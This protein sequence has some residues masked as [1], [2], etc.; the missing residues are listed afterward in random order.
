MRALAS[1]AGSDGDGGFNRGGRDD[2]NA[3]NLD[4]DKDLYGILGLERG[5]SPAKIKA[6]Y[7]R[8]AKEC[9]PD[10]VSPE[11]ADAAADRFRQVS[12]AHHTLLHTSLRRMYDLH[13][14]RVEGI[15]A[16]ADEEDRLA[17]RLGRAKPLVYGLGFS[18]AGIAALMVLVYCGQ[19]SFWSVFRY[20]PEWVPGKYYLPELHLQLH[21][22]V[23]EFRRPASA[24]SQS[25]T[26]V[27]KAASP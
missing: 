13:L 10:A 9:H 23:R 8:I 17:G 7:R 12:H 18:A 3:V 19:W 21:E 24:P 5:A 20:I 14:R 6:A 22:A 25:D 2:A 16:C 27:V 11:E 26:V 1:T 15:N 4:L